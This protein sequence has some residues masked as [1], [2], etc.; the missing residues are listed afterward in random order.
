MNS[1]SAS[2]PL[3]MNLCQEED[4]NL[5]SPKWR[6]LA[7]AELCHW[8]LTGASSRRICH[9]CFWKSHQLVSMSPEA[10]H[11]QPCSIYR[12]RCSEFSQGSENGLSR[13]EQI[14]KSVM[15]YRGKLKI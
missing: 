4:K 8:L 14:T 2:H 11:I 7:T 15:Y 3:D 10:L 9:S 6:S 1:N 13:Q 5:A 12:K